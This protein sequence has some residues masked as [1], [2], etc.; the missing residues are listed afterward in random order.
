M[1]LGASELWDGCCITLK[2]VVFLSAA[3]G[4]AQRQGFLSSC[5]GFIEVNR[6]TFGY[7]IG[8]KKEKIRTKFKKKKKH[9]REDSVLSHSCLLLCFWYDHCP[10]CVCES[11]YRGVWFIGLCTC[12]TVHVCTYVMYV[13]IYAGWVHAC[14]LCAVHDDGPALSVTL[15]WYAVLIWKYGPCQTLTTACPAVMWEILCIL[16]NDSCFW[17]QNANRS[18]SSTTASPLHGK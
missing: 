10:Q 18:P 5:Y 15:L 4:Q 11:Q 13:H 2:E 9:K 17:V 3:G 12:A 7:R 6:V 14:V 8:R 1:A 16:W